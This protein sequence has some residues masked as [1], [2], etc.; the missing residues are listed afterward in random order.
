[1]SRRWIRAATVLG[2]LV[3]LSASAA[4]QP[5]PLYSVVWGEQG[6]TVQVESHGCT[7]REDF[8][9]QLQAVAVGESAALSQLQLQ[10]KQPDRCRR[11]PYL[12]SLFFAWSQ[13]PG[14][15]SAAIQAGKPFTLSNPLL[16]SAR[17]QP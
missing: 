7:R 16:L 13:L 5:E 9:W 6:T 12:Q 17:M 3:S 8:V 2:A 15:A 10:R 1:M 11:K 14:E 4:S